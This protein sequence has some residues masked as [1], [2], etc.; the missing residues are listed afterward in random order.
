M[1]MQIRKSPTVGLLALLAGCGGKPPNVPTGEST[2]TLEL[3]CTLT[4]VCR[5][6]TKLVN[7]ENGACPPNSVPDC[8]DPN[9]NCCPTNGTGVYTAENGFAGIGTSR[10]MITHFNNKPACDGNSCVTFDGQCA[11]HDGL[12][13][14]LV[15]QG[16][17]VGASYN[18]ASYN[19]RSVS[20]DGTKPIWILE[21]LTNKTGPM[22][23]AGNDI[24][25]LS[26]A[27]NITI[28]IR[29]TERILNQSYVLSFNSPQ[30]ISHDDA[31]PVYT[32]NMQWR[33]VGQNGPAKDYCVA[34]YASHGGWTH[35]VRDPIV[36]QKDIVV[37][38]SF[39][40]V[41]HVSQGEVVTLS[42][43]NGA[44]ATVYDWGYDYH[45]SGASGAFD[46]AIQMK[47]ASY[48]GDAQHY[49]IAGTPID[50]FNDPSHHHNGLE[51]IWEPDGARCVNI[52]NLRHPELGFSKCPTRN[53]KP[54]DEVAL[55]VPYLASGK[56]Q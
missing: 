47:R 55:P 18:G 39:G 28:L 34:P 46:A 17:F 45:A 23:V 38:P 31:H 30:V 12:W 10:F 44:L 29:N 32:Y 5:E 27:I 11:A 50:I 8:P 20:E 14:C 19:I 52:S 56:V 15:G 48:C 40:K 13:S 43:R 36:F 2:S 6:G 51:A 42:C 35:F 53:L 9:T 26:L 4:K 24:Q 49:T 21:G 1:L 25:H 37:D 16:T 7:A 3:A 22:V 54:C 33:E 41:D